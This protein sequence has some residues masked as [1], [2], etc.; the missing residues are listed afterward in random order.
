[1][2]RFPGFW[3][4]RAAL[5]G[6]LLAPLGLVFASL[7]AARRLA[8]RRGWFRPVRLAVPVVVVGNIFV[9]GTGKTPLVAW[10]V[11]RLQAQ[12]YRPGILVRGYGGRSPRWPVLVDAGSDPRL[13]GDEAVLLARR[14]GVP[15]AAGPD[16]P[17]AG[18]RL[19][20]QG[21]DVL[22][23][24]D[25]LQ[26]HRLARDVE[27]VVLD[28]ARGLGSGRCLPAGPLR[29]PPRRLADVDLVLCNGAAVG[30]CTDT[31][32]LMP[33]PLVP[34]LSG[35][36]VDPTDWRGR[37]VHA[38]AGIGNPQRFFDALAAQGLQ[39]IPHPFPDHHPYGPADLAFGDGL[40]ILMTEK[41]AVKVRSFAP[42]RC[43]YQPVT[44]ALAPA[45]E[46]RVMDILARRLGR[47]PA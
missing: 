9:G 35:D 12:G 43:W 20:E 38:V 28:G 17:A 41:D 36:P 23:S 25:G 32:E 37:A 44:A 8:Y 30:D 26:H 2:P 40:P 13:V 3:L 47:Q 21:C 1:M 15:V 46:A 34:L 33:G 19:I 18:R 14:T 39:P 22:V 4:D 27:L 29:E 10:L 42:Q 31:F 6:R 5:P 11:Q 16:R 24:D 45:T 7:A